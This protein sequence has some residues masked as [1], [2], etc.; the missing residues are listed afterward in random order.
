MK[1]NKDERMSWQEF[2]ELYLPKV[3][4]LADMLGIEREEMINFCTV[5][6]PKDSWW[7]D[8]IDDDWK[9]I[10]GVMNTIY[11]CPLKH[12]RRY[13]YERLERT[14]GAKEIFDEVYRIWASVT[15]SIA[16]GIHFYETYPLSEK[17]SEFGKGDIID[18]FSLDD[19]NN[20]G[21]IIEIGGGEDLA[22]TNFSVVVKVKHS[23]RL[24]NWEV[25]GALRDLAD[26]IEA[27]FKNCFHSCLP[28]T[29]NV[30]TKEVQAILCGLHK[31]NP[32]L[33]NEV[34]DWDTRMG[35]FE[36]IREAGWIDPELR[37]SSMSPA[38]AGIRKVL[39]MIRPDLLEQ[40]LAEKMTPFEALIEIG[41][42]EPSDVYRLCRKGS[43]N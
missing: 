30:T 38:F 13:R 24:A 42:V 27:D 17:P 6:L 28:R 10:Y 5:D 40:I 32:E 21:I 29:Y 23:G 20:E 41:W 19:P 7:H 11:R 2:K 36:A 37:V 9:F 15:Y 34:V 31:S 33:H 25:P 39:E 3:E 18:I 4:K 22:D 43:E 8:V 16:K 1:E 14:K 12:E 35:L 26:S